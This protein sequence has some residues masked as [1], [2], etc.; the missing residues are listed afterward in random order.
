MSGIPVNTA[1]MGITV[2][3]YGVTHNPCVSI[4]VKS[5]TVFVFIWAG[6]TWFEQT[7]INVDES[8]W[9]CDVR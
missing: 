8:C 5:N 2:L 6:L 1:H 3:E 7:I 9:H 4:C